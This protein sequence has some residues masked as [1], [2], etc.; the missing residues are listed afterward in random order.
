[1]ARLPA[2][3]SERGPPRLVGSAFVVDVPS[4]LLC[5]CCHVVDDISNMARMAS[6]TNPILDPRVHGVALGFGSPAEWRGVAHVRAI[7][8][9][10]APRDERNGLD[11][12]VLEL[13]A[14]LPL[15]QS[16][17]TPPPPPTITTAGDAAA[18]V[19]ARLSTKVPQSRETYTD[20][21]DSSGVSSASPSPSLSPRGA[22]SP[23]GEPPPCGPADAAPDGHLFALPIGTEDALA[24]GDEVVLLG[25]AS[26][27]VPPAPPPP[28]PRRTRRED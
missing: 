6:P 1:M 7:S 3:R 16:P 9:P 20:V 28:R 26:P 17:L 12:A 21:E 10:P 13:T 8:P 24:I 5:T 11:L 23:R 4:R 15:S 2:P 27:G 22:A 25:C 19:G 18:A 14:L